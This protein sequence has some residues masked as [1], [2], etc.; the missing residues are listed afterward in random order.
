MTPREKAISAV[1]LGA[2]VLYFAMLFG[3]PLVRLLG[4]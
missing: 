2:V 3:P 1:L 4:G